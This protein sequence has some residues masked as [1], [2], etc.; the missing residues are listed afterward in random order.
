MK[1]RRTLEREAVVLRVDPGD[2]SSGVFRDAAV[3][4]CLSAPLDASCLEA[5]RIGVRDASGTVPGELALSGDGCVLI[6]RATR[7]LVPDTV[8]F[9]V[10]DGLRDRR[11]RP[12]PGHIS[13]F[14]PCA[15]DFAELPD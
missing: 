7:K 6:W 8:H 2:G 15:V 1:P 9:V 3:A 5:A 4:L 12:F 13:R 14:V 11:G 10:A